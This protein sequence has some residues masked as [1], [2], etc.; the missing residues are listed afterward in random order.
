MRIPTTTSKIIKKIYCIPFCTV[1]L[2]FEEPTENKMNE[3][4]KEKAILKKLLIPFGKKIGETT[5][6]Q[7]T[8]ININ[9]KIF[10][11]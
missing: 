8:L 6:K 3:K 11:S 5:K 4:Q 2:K 10:K 9:N 7:L 1:I